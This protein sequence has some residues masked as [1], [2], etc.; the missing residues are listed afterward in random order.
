MGSIQDPEDLSGTLYSK[1][2]ISQGVRDEIQEPCGL[3]KRRKCETLIN[4][5]ETSIST[6]PQ[7]FHVFIG[8][9]ESMPYISALAATMVSTVGG[10]SVDINGEVSYYILL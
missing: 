9:L 10:F 4:A 8:V 7:A 6:N 1:S 2:I 3:T 5:V